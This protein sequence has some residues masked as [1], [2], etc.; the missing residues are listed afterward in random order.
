[1]IPQKIGPHGHYMDHYPEKK[2]KGLADVEAVIAGVQ[3]PANFVHDFVIEPYYYADPF[4]KLSKRQEKAINIGIN[5]IEI[6]RTILQGVETVG[7]GAALIVQAVHVQETKQL[8]KIKEGQLRQ[9]PLDHRLKIHVE[10]LRKYLAAQW[11]VLK[12][13]IADF[14]SIFL[15]ASLNTISFVTD[16]FKGVIPR[17]NSVVCWAFYLL[18]VLT[19]A[20][21]L[22]RA[23][24]AKTTHETWMVQIAK[25]QR[26]FQFQQAEALLHKRQERMILRKAE[27]LSFEELQTILEE[28]GVDFTENRIS[29]FEDFKERLVDTTFRKEIVEN[30]LDEEDEKRDTIQTMTR[31]GIQALADAKIRNEKKFFNFNLASSSI[32]VVLASLSAAVAIILEALT[33][34]GIVAITATTLA[35]PVLGLYILGWGVFAVG[36][37]FFYKHRPNLFKCYLKGINL[38]LAI[39]QIPAKIRNLQLNGTKREIRDLEGRESLKSKSIARLNVLREREKVLSK[40]VNAWMGK[41]GIITKLHDQ[42]REAGNKDFA[43]ENRLMNTV[44]NE[45]IDI[46]EVITENIF[47]GGFDEETL[48]ILKAKMGVDIKQIPRAAGKEDKEKFIGTL[49]EFFKMDEAEVLSFMKQKLSS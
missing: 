10:K 34:A 37:Y 23:Q 22:W 19:T 48:R 9:N 39:F 26:T 24:K 33:F 20:I 12:N 49:K 14:I 6:P 8:L 2:D 15:T 27:K 29:T 4:L 7:S 17:V 25:D 45:K 3:T 30:F 36:L 40:K 5:A 21:S 28:K 47:D 43:R 42:L 32:N 41:G 44:G 18:D 11:E 13:K 1:M 35:M 31:K 46:A 38:R 16:A